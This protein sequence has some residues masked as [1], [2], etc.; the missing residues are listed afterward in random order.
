MFHFW[1]G[2]GL[3]GLND[4]LYN[5]QRD[6]NRYTQNSFMNCFYDEGA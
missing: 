1:S 6:L 4:E 5:G 3:V 2:Y